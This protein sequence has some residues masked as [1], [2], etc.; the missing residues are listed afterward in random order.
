MCGA[1]RPL[2][3]VGSSLWFSNAMMLAAMALL[4]AFMWRGRLGR[5]EGAVLLSLYAFYL[6]GLA[7][8]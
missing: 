4:L 2:T 3:V 1:D 8:L 6:V 7:I 5:S